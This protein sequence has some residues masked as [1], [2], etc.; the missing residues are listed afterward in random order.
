VVSASVAGSKI[1]FDEYSFQLDQEQ[2]VAKSV[3]FRNAM[4]Y[5]FA[6]KIRRGSRMAPASV[7]T[8]VEQGDKS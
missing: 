1:W 8:N 3:Q 4:K 7:Q 5:P 6:G 2:T